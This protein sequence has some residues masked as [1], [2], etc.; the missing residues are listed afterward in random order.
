MK[1]IPSYRIELPEFSGINYT[2]MMEI[3][4]FYIFQER[5]AEIS[6]KNLILN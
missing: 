2:R 4:H 5:L 6:L 3:M 1:E